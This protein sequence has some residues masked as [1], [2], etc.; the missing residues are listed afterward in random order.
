M[1]KY[2]ALEEQKEELT[3]ALEST[4]SPTQQREVLLQQVKTD[5]ADIDTLVKVKKS[6]EEDLE[7]K[8]TRLAELESELDVKDNARLKKHKELRERGE[9]MRSFI[10][11]FDEKYNGAK[12]K[13]EENQEKILIA[14]EYLSENITDLDLNDLDNVQYEL[15]QQ[16]SL[17]G[18]NNKYSLLFSQ[19]TRV[20]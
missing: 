20:S 14:L 4:L 3:A 5:K 10:A 15:D 7:A 12:E 2:S 13:I 11:S 6:L 8:R 18:W 9:H 1:K 19:V 16:G 17:E